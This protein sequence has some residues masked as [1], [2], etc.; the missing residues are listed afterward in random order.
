[1]KNIR[2]TLVFDM[3]NNDGKVDDSVKDIMSKGVTINKKQMASAFY[4]IEKNLRYI[5]KTEVLK[6]IDDG[7]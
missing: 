3:L 7:R 6:A 4:V 2:E 5:M 1:M